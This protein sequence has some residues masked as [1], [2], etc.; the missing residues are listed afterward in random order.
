[1]SLNIALKHVFST[2]GL[3][4]RTLTTA[5][6]A[7]QHL[8]LAPAH[9]HQDYD[10]PNNQYN[11]A[12]RI[13][14]VRHG[15][16]MG[17]VDESTYVS[18]ADWRIP[19]TS[20]GKHQAVQAGSTIAK[21]IGKQGNTFFYV[22]PYMRTRQTLKGIMTQIPRTQIH[23]LREEPRIAEQQFGNFQNVQRVQEAKVERKRFGRFF[24]RFPNGEAGFDVY[25]RVTSFISTVMRD[26]TQFR[27]E[28]Q[29][30][31]NFNICIVTHGLTLRLFLMRWFQYSVTEFEDSFNPNNGAVVVLERKTNAKTGLQWYELTKESRKSLN[32]P[33]YENQQRFHIMD[34]LEILDH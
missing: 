34:D 4:T 19:L 13:I 32:L 2:L 16:S 26:C 28:Q 22:S 31:D 3:R 18:Q 23:G 30:F 11:R 17:N 15:E 5:T 29:D 25:S 1:M 27:A 8:S 10:F 6:K 21:L 9:D 20:E 14:L 24:Y 12:K 33:I 7:T